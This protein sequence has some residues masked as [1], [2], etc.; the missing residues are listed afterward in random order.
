MTQ[1]AKELKRKEGK[2]PNNSTVVSIII[3]WI[4][5]DLLEIET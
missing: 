2:N 4:G 5:I 3:S 1:K